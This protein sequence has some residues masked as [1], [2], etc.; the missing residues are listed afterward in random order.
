MPP[1]PPLLLMPSPFTSL[2]VEPDIVPKQLRLKRIGTMIDNF[3][4]DIMMSMY[5]QCLFI[6]CCACAFVFCNCNQENL[7][8]LM[9]D[10]V[11]KFVMPLVSF[12]Y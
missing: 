6:F 10:D 11:N 1:P 9:I 8:V 2:I 5:R 7:I 4:V 12:D 3:I